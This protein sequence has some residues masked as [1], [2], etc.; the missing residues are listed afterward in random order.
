MSHEKAVQR[1]SRPLYRQVHDE[2][3]HRLGEV[4]W[5]QTNS[6]LFHHTIKYQ[7]N[8]IQ[9]ITRSQEAIQALH[10]HIWKVVHQVMESAGKPTADGLEIALHLVDMLLSIPPQLTFNTVTAELPRFTPEALTYA[11]PLSI[12]QGAMT[13]LSAKKY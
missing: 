11:S 1:A 13:I 2:A 9:L 10:E 12:N 7:N 6:L 8:M 4:T 3:T 5:L